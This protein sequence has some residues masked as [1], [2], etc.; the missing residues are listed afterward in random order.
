MMKKQN[1]RSPGTILS[2]CLFLTLTVTFFSPMEVVLMNAGE[3]NFPFENV[4]WFQLGIALAAG[5][6]L[7]LVLLAL[8]P[9]AGRIAAA[10]P[11]G[12]GLA[13]YV[14]AMFLNGAMV[15]LTGARMKLTDGERTGNLVIWALILLAV[16]I[17]TVLLQRKNRKRTDLVMR[18]L[19]L[20]L[21]AV[22]SA[23][24]VS[25]ALTGG[26]PEK[27]PEQYLSVEGEFEL[28]RDT[29]VIEFVLDTAD[30]TFVRRMLE[31]FPELSDSLAGWVYYPNATS[32]HSRT[33]PSIPYMLT[34]EICH[35]DVPVSDYVDRAFE[36]SGFLKGLYE[37]GTDI[38]IFTWDPALVS[39]SAG[40]YIANSSGYKYSRFENLNL[41]KLEENLMHIALYKSLPYQF[42]N[43]FQYNIVLI[44]YN[45]F[46]M[47]EAFNRD[48]SYMDPSF[49]N[50]L[51]IYDPMT[52][53]DGYSRAYRFYHLFGTH[54][55][56]DWDEN[57]EGAED[58]EEAA[59]DLD[60]RA[61]ALRGSFRM[62][63]E[64]I[65][66]MKELGLYDRATIIVTADHGISDD[67]DMVTNLD[68]KTVSCP[69]MMVK[70]AQCDQSR[71]MQVDSSPVA[72][73]D[74]FAT[75]EEALG[76]PV[77]GTGS[78][79][80]L[81]EYT[82]DEPRDRFYYHSA[83]RSDEEGEIALREYLIDGDAEELS[84]WHITG[85]W[86]PVLYSENTVSD[87]KFEE[88]PEAKGN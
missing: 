67:E 75:V 27:K 83:F 73:E 5:L 45:S 29:N 88:L 78:G 69:I 19:S 41:P 12:L 4:W 65:G 13:A 34:G 9:R 85:N 16:L 48:F 21:I 81:N 55:G 79:R 86:W 47:S 50:D 10:V 36:N 84:N 38:R 17:G 62:I 35:M 51:M 11:L 82:K 2:C 43:S 28:A 74:I 20:A 26:T 64:Y 7:S 54:P 1:R 68:R 46:R 3:F 6:L 76:A 24:M 33:Y 72:H 14:Q 87:E 58:A 23:A 31:L 59:W 71:P 49:R 18:G 42:K 37:K 66:C 15:S 56:A 57:L 63:E 70:Y 25:Q 77:S 22:Q 52:V 8:P 44:N 53:T 80:A 61:R 32:T 39:A 60:F 30:G 40:D